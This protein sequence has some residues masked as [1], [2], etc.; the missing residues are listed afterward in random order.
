MALTHRKVGAREITITISIVIWL[1]GLSGGISNVVLQ[2]VAVHNGECAWIFNADTAQ[3][4]F[5]EGLITIA[6]GYI[7]PLILLGVLYALVIRELATKRTTSSNKDF[8]YLA[9]RK[10]IKML[11]VVFALYVI[12]WTGV[13]VAYFLTITNLFFFD[14]LYI[15]VQNIAY[16][17]FC[18]NPFIYIYHIKSYRE[19]MIKLFVK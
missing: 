14:T 6:A 3:L 7:T 19:K 13:T 4:I 2:N 18:C 12:C 10:T 5:I 11:L 15:I 9:K 1:L 8:K 17:N 16:L